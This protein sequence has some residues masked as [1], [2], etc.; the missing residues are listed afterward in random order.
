MT[1]LATSRSK[2]ATSSSK[3]TALS[4]L[5]EKHPTRTP[6]I[7]RIDDNI[8]SDQKGKLKYL[9]P[10]NMTVGEFMCL[11]RRRLK[12]KAEKGIFMFVNNVLPSI[13]STMGELHNIHENKEGILELTVKME[14]T[15]G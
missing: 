9:V 6:I 10:N 1:N 13:T 5:L 11:I 14:N 7:V 4:N 12:M 2:L 15:F 3:T 8:G